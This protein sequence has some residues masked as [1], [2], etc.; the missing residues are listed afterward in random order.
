[1]PRR[2]I[3]SKERS[4][5]KFDSTEETEKEE[6]GDTILNSLAQEQISMK[7]AEFPKRRTRFSEFSAIFAVNL[8]EGITPGRATPP[9]P[10]VSQ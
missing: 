1:M 9:D 8:S 7:S 4:R 3:R 5:G 10:A 2:K 6:F